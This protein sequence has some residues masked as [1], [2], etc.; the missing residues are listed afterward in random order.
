M[1][2]HPEHIIEI[3]NDPTLIAS[4]TEKEETQVKRRTDRKTEDRGKLRKCETEDKREK[5]KVE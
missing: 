4:I 3:Q 5:Q 1:D 2:V